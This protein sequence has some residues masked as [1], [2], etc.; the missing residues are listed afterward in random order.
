[1]PSAASRGAGGLPQSPH[2][3]KN[4]SHAHALK[5]PS[6][7]NGPNAAKRPNAADRGAGGVFPLRK[8]TP[9]RR[10]QEAKRSKKPIAAKQ[11]SAAGRGPEYLPPHKKNTHA[12]ALKGQSAANGPSAAKRPSAVGRGGWGSLPTKYHGTFGNIVRSRSDYR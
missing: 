1:M 8:N 11:R 5:V 4:T 10:A 3:N 9:R 6:A 2:N 7:A 12:H